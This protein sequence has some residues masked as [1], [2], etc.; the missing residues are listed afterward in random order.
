MRQ[1]LKKII[2]FFVI[3]ILIAVSLYWIT[4][5]FR[6]NKKFSLDRISTVNREYLSF[7]L[8]KKQHPT[9]QFNSFIFG[10]SRAGGL[11]SYVWKDLLEK[12]EKQKDSVSQFLFQAWGESIGGILQKMEYLS[13]HNVAL[14]NVLILIDVPKFM[15]DEMNKNEILSLEHFELSGKSKVS[16]FGTFLWAYITTPSE[17]IKSIRNISSNPDINFDTITND[18]N[19]ENRNH[20]TMKPQQNLTLNKSRFYNRSKHE[21]F[22][23]KFIDTA[24]MYML[25]RIKDIFDENETNY[26][27]VISPNYDQIHINVDDLKE[28][29]AIFGEENVFN[30]SG[31]N[32]LTKDPYDYFDIN[33]FDLSVGWEILHTIYN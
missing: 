15:N 4:D 19:K 10:S 8:F 3:P 12:H 2:I 31:K 30:F 11:N 18:W 22:S 13:K 1:F 6:I 14:N 25:R 27:I 5:P 29:K 26:K 17:I 23:N 28:I 21:V 33:H 24:Y 20:K 7:E 16:Y 32:E 9:Y